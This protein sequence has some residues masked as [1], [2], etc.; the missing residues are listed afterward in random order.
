MAGTGVGTAF[1]ILFIVL[2]I[3]NV[4][5]VYIDPTTD[6]LSLLNLPNVVANLVITLLA[7]G[8]LT[9]SVLGSGLSDQFTRVLVSVSLM[10]SMLFSV[11]VFMLTFGMGLG[12]RLMALPGDPFGIWAFLIDSYVLVTFVLGLVTLAGGE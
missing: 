7:L 3:A 6:P 5:V 2:L 4:A 1:G 11:P 8:V 9:V 10:L 12:S